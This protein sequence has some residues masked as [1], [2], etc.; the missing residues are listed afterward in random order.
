MQFIDMTCPKC[1]AA[2]KVDTKQGRAS[3]EYCGH[4]MLIEKEDTLEEIR[5]KAQSRSYGYHKG[6]LKAEAEAAAQRREKQKKWKIPVIIV[7]VILFLGVFSA[8]ST[9]LAKPKV[10]PFE[11]IEVSFQGKDG[12]G[13]LE[14]TV[15]APSGI[16]VNYIDY[17]ISK[18][19]HLYQGETI[20]IQARSN[21]Y[22]LEENTRTYVVEGLD[23]YLKDLQNIPQDA[24]ALIHAKAENALELNLDGPKALGYLKEMKPVKLF[25]T[26]DGKQ[27]NELYDVFQVDFQTGDSESTYYVLA[28]FSDVIVRNREQVSID[29]PYGIYLGHLTQVQ[30]ACYIMAYDSLEE[31]K[32]DILTSQD[33]YVELKELDLISQ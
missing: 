20:T 12:R 7:A 28:C 24:L 21:T 30:G 8:G 9:Q 2:L 31:V 15:V 3:C 13:E 22:R 5:Q 29:M 25:L 19:S 14:L 23:E 27:S 26:T 4:L 11:C 16:D 1:G 6:K 32:T 18:D 10:N 17:D 33:S